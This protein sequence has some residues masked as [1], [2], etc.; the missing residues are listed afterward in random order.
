MK[1]MKV[2]RSLL[3]NGTMTRNGGVVTKMVL[4]NL[5]LDKVIKKAR[6]VKIVL[7]K[8]D[9]G[10][11]NLKMEEAPNLDRMVKV[12]KVV[13]EV[14]VQIMEL[15]NPEVDLAKIKKARVVKTVLVKVDKTNLNQNS[16]LLKVGRIVHN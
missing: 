9:H 14:K 13:G 3:G 16:H 5:N 8:V 6:V 12:P 11:P 1:V 10:V 7:D 15:D 4:P 2:L